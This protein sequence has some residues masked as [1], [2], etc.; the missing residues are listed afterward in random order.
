MKTLKVCIAGALLVATLTAYAIVA[1]AHSF[2]ESET[3]SAGQT[4]A[5]APSEVVINFDA[6]IE[7]LFAKVEVIGTDGK[8]D[9]AVRASSQRRQAP[10]DGQV[11]VL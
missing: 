4:I 6:P 9:A 11:A 2:P 3:P 10:V 1:S 5:A 7:K 8:N